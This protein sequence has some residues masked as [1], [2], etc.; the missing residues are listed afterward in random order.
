M[1]KSKL[2]L[3]LLFVASLANC[4]KVPAG[5]VGVKVYLLGQS[6]GVDHEVLGVGRYYIGINED[7]F[8]FPTYKINKIWTADDREDSPGN[9]EMTFQTKEG[10]SV[11]ADVGITYNVDPKQVGTL[12]QTYRKGMDEITSIYLRA[13]VRD[14]L[15]R[16]ASTYTVED[17]YGVKKSEI[18]DKALSDIRKDLEPKGILVEKLYWIGS[19]RLPQTV[20]TALNAK[21]EATQMAQQRENEVAQAKAEA[22]KKVAEARG[23]A[24][25]LRLKA[26]SITQSNLELERLQIQKTLAEKWDGHLPTTMVPGQTVPFLNVK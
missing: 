24:E 6:K 13:Y 15:N 18:L 19:I 17:M 8:L 5:Y 9:E 25:S 3:A 23:E 21:I 12:F 11:S 1:K 26:M 16:I 20:V 14:A 7:L 10:L 22:D 4:S 2:L